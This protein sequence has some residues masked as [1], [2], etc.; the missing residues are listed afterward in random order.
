MISILTSA[1]TIYFYLNGRLQ[2]LYGYG[3]RPD[4]KAV[5]SERPLVVLTLQLKTLKL[6]HSMACR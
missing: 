4:L 2:I 5:Q 6:H 1:L 3:L